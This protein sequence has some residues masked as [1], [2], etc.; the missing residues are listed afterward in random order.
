MAAMK[1]KIKE[2]ESKVRMNICNIFLFHLWD[3]QI[4]A[5]GFSKISDSADKKN[6]ENWKM[7]N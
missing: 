4:Y 7:V 6:Y 2:A 3:C 5:P 1:H